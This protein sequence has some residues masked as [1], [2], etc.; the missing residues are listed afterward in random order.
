MSPQSIS[1]NRSVNL[2][3]IAA[4]AGVSRST[5][6]RVVN[7]EPHVSAKTR[8][9]VLAVIRQE[10]YT[11][12][13]AARALVTQ[14]TQVIGVVIPQVPIV[15]FED[16]YYFP[17]LLQGISRV[18]HA[19]DY[20]MLLWLGQ[21]EEEERR[22]YQRVISNRLMDGVII[23]SAAADNPFIDH[24]LETNTPFV[25][26]ERPDRYQDQISYVTIDNES[27][28]YDVVTHLVTLGRHRIGTVTGN[29]TIMDGVDRLAGYR[30]A[31]SDSGLLMDEAL[32]A[33]GD[34]T[35]RAG[36]Q[37]AFRLLDQGVDAIFAASD[38]TAR[39]VFQALQERQVQVPDDVAVVGFDDLP[40]AVH[41]SPSLTTVHHPIEQKGADAATIL[42]DQIMGKVTTPQQRILPTHLVIRKSCGAMTG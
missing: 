21:S 39:G 34:F 18:T 23:A 26:V 27:A 6:S 1:P 3:D 7:N 10:G 17:M 16:A 2:E 36:Y 42:L 4:K 11:P 24:F 5:V 31:L 22:Y 8:E 12:N 37:G 41:I 35:Y 19:R 13:P 28:A 33:E 29:L 38:I 40:T 9:R 15:L 30:R 20:A 14:R 32:I 25:L